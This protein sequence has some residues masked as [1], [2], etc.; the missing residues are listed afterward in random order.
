MTTHV[1]HVLHTLETGGTENGVVNL[2]NTLNSGFTHSV[3]TMSTIGRMAERLPSDV[4]RHA[5]GKRP[6]LDLR[7]TARLVVLLRR[8]RP[9]VVHSRNWATFDAIL[10]ARIARVP[11]VIHGEHG[12]E[13][14]DPRGLNR[15]RNAARRVC[16]PLVSRFVAVSD[17]LR[18]WLIETVG[19]AANKVETIHNGVDAERFTEHGREAAR[20]A[21]GLAGEAVVIGTVGRL[22]PVKH[23]S[24]LI[25]AFALISDPRRQLALLIVGD[26]PCR[27]ELQRRAGRPDVAGRV[28][29]LGDRAD[30]PMV[31]KALDVFA[32]PSV[33]EGISNTVLEAMA[34]GL[35]VVATRVGG[36]PELVEDGVT[37]ALVGVGDCRALAF[38]LHRYV[39][40]PH[41]AAL[42]G[43]AG[44]HRVLEQFTL[45]GMAGRYRDLYVS[46]TR[47]AA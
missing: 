4:A 25:D 30:I 38:A 10:A 20:R 32:L 47:A 33:A 9:D 46:L 39:S 43:K 28:H 15:R 45:D 40:D 23:H 34:T 19:I 14:A 1:V 13:I 37:G 12:R 16:A 31:L 7:T 41:L 17:D 21:L 26:G 18:R 3:I 44:R 35:P 8:L 29:L 5:L 24:G 11:T 22:D 42:H 36:N 27:A 2:V 6:G